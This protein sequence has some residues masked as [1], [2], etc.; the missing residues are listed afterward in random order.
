MQS[1]FQKQG[2]PDTNLLEEYIFGKSGPAE[3]K[4][5][6]LA[7]SVKARQRRKDVREIKEKRSKK[8]D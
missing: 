1:R 4:A 7:R 5:D 3:K 8:E 6:R 2:K